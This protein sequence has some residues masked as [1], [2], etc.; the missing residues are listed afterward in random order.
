MR[1]VLFWGYKRK[2]PLAFPNA[3][4]SAFL[5]G[6]YTT[7]VLRD[8]LPKVLSSGLQLC[9][10]SR[11][12]TDCFAPDDVANIAAEA[13]MLAPCLRDILP[14]MQRQQMSREVFEE[15]QAQHIHHMPDAVQM[16]F[17]MVPGRCTSLA[18]GSSCEV[19]GEWRER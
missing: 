3:P 17:T 14:K 6:F 2:S 9:R 18:L 4:Q 1:G 7:T 11:Q 10:K 12:V 19:G 5:D 16:R 15:K 8:I 13:A